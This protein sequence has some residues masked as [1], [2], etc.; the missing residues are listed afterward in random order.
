MKRID[1]NPTFDSSLQT[2]PTAPSI[3]EEGVGETAVVG[4]E[5]MPDVVTT[6]ATTTITTI[7]TA[8][9]QAKQSGEK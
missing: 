2:E 8:T 6:T 7:I 3:E 5:G 4:K 1:N 9:E